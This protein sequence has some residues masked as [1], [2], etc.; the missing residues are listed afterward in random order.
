MRLNRTDTGI[1]VILETPTAEVLKP[2]IT[3]QGN[4]LI[5]DIPNAVLVLPESSEFRAD[6]PIVGIT[7]VT[8]TNQETSKIRVTVTG[9]SNVPVV[10]LFNIDA[11]LIFGITPEQTAT[12][13]EQIE[14]LVTGERE[15]GYSVPNAATATRT[16]TPLR[17]IPQSIQVVPQ[18]VIED[19]QVTQI[20]DA[21]RNVSGVTPRVEYGANYTYNIRGFSSSRQLRNGV[22]FRSGGF[23]VGS[24]TTPGNF[25]RIEILKGPASVLYGQAEPGGVVNFV[26]KQPLSAPYYAAEFTA[27]SYSFYEPSVDL[28]GSLTDDKSLLYR[29]NASDQNFGSFLLTI[30]FGCN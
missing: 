8:V 2:I 27:G 22:N 26:T 9:Q 10:E 17:D 6:N 21:L 11:G 5:A 7:L 15:A 14:V 25:E 29:L 4:T 20:S 23:I 30:R 13:D 16:D 18:Q 12:N 19:Q 1:E 28:S 3:Q 24:P